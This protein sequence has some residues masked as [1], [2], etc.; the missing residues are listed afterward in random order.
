MLVST[1]SIDFP[2]HTTRMVSLNA[3]ANDSN[4]RDRCGHLSKNYISPE[5]LGYALSGIRSS[6]MSSLFDRKN[7][8]QSTNLMRPLLCAST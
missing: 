5:A 4:S 1:T 3:S 8:R 2:Q 6:S 7:E